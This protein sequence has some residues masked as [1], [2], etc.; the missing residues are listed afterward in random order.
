MEK[1]WSSRDSKKSSIVMVPRGSFGPGSSLEEGDEWML[2]S[3]HL[4]NKLYYCSTCS[5]VR[6]IFHKHN[7]FPWADTSLHVIL[8]TER[9]PWSAVTHLWRTC[10]KIQNPPHS[11]SATIWNFK[12]SV[13]RLG[14]LYTPSDD[15]DV[16]CSFTLRCE[17]ATTPYGQKL[18]FSREID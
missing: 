14:H 18:R 6:M 13:D 9:D 10:L 15:D 8:L 3:A 16:G 4:S 1:I 12:Q 7:S 11:G 5:A 17:S 2:I